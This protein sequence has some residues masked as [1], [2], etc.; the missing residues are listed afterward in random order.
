MQQTLTIQEK[1]KDLRVIEKKMTLKQVAE[2]TG[3]SV[4]SLSN[5]ESNDF[6]DISPFAIVT[7]AKF[8]GVSTDYLL[9]LTESR[10]HPDAEMASL[11]LSDGA[12]EVLRSGTIN[13]RLL[14]EWITHEKFRLLMYDMEIFVDRIADMRIQNMNA[15]MEATRQQIIQK[16]HPDT[17]DVY[18]RTLELV[19]INE[20]DYFSRIVHD[21]MDVILRDLREAHRK[22]STTA[23]EGAGITGNDV[24]ELMEKATSMPVEDTIADAIFQKL[25][26][27]R[28]QLTDEELTA[29]ISVLSKATKKS[30]VIN[31]RGRFIPHGHG[32][33]KRKRG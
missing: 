23:D 5:Y 18:T 11:H 4:S 8:Y 13:H 27:P 9:G 21:D 24:K 25:G 14:N 32:T 3:I 19:Q 20:L 15:V 1:L 10:N 28:D 17:E 26:I 6:K 31:M 12:L 33:G 29:F 22:D 2:Q 16:Y 7:L 30:S